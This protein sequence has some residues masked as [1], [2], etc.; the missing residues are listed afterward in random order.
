MTIDRLITL[1]VGRT[2]DQIYP[3]RE[4]GDP[5]P[6]RPCSRSSGLTQPGV[7]KD[8]S[9][10]V[11]PGEVVGVSG[12][13]GSGRSEMAR[14]LFG[15]D[16]FA[17]GTIAI[18]G[19]ALDRARRRKPAMDRGMAFLTEDRRAEGLMMA[20]PIA[21]NVGA[22]F[23][24]ALRRRLRPPARADAARRRG[25]AHRPRGP[26]QR[27][28][29]RPDAGQEPF[30]RQPAEGGDR[31]V[32]AARPAPVHPR[33]ADPRHRR[34]RQVRGLQADQPLGR[35]RHR[36]AHDLLGDRG[37]DRDVRPHPGHGPRRDP[38]IV[39]ARRS[40]IARR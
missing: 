3:P 17:S 37:A 23:A 32:A 13:M 10:T 2:I 31:Q 39:R 1:M 15:L 5:A 6:A 25:R 30:G 36:R 11:Q 28:R 14:I 35:R 27:A 24:A 29:F 19:A 7:V 38:G 12:L 20:A 16:R 4:H 18:D 26:G 22:R 8:I 40:S 33:R 21:D 9:F 34:R